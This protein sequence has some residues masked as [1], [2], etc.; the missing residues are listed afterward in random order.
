MSTHRIARLVALGRTMPY[1]G[2]HAKISPIL[3]Y[4]LPI[5]YVQIVP[6]PHGQ[7]ALV[8]GGGAAA[9]AAAALLRAELRLGAVLAHRHHQPRP[10]P[11]LPA[12]RDHFLK[13]QREFA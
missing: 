9:G 6:R 11:L 10:A 13:H 3:Q 7:D 4:I 2:V 8:L 5:F 12:H 1:S